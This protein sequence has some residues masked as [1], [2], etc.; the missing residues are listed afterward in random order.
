MISTLRLLF[1]KIGVDGAIFYTSFARIISAFTGIIS[2]VFIARFLTGIEQGFY[3]TFGSVLALQVFFELG[4]NSIITQYVAHEVAHLNWESKSK[5]SGNQL[6]LSR[7]SSLLHFTVKWYLVFAGFLFAIL[8]IAG[9][10]FFKRYDRSGGAVE[11]VIPW[12]LLASSTTIAFLINPILAF[13]EGLGKVKQVAQ[14]RLGQQLVNTF[15]I[16]ITLSFN[17]KLFSSGISSILGLIVVLGWVFAGT[18][19]NL[20]TYIWKALD[21]ERVNYYKEIFPYQWKIALSWVSGYFISQLFNPV[22]FATEGAVVAGQMGMTLVVLNGIFSLSFSWMSTKVPLYSGLIAQKKYIELD[23]VFD[24]TLKQSA[25]IN[26]L[27]LSA[28]FIISFGLRYFSI[29][30]GNRFLPYL[31]LIL[32]MI[33]VF[34]NQFVSSWATYLRCHKQEPF[35]IPSIVGGVATSLST[36]IFGKYFGVIGMTL[37]YCTLTFSLGFVWGFIIFKNKKREWHRLSL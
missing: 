33:P 13:L 14:I 3:Y 34:L 26:G 36:V 8:L 12:L 27:G 16:W 5:L 19:K 9:Y 21:K 35:L 31:P 20:L 37:G 4:L 30:L 15:L 6:H 32:M 24:K 22:L 11:W 28:F 2:V 7:L 10:L 23:S 29:P 1:S 18:Y 17:A 25:A